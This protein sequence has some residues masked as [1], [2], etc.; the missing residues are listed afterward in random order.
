L[1]GLDVSS[2]EDS[3][4]ERGGKCLNCG[5]NIMDPIHK[6]HSFCNDCW[7]LLLKHPYSLEDGGC[8]YCDEPEDHPFHTSWSQADEDFA[9]DHGISYRD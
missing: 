3:K 9:V 7:I 4:R 5:I 6:D 8:A 2:L 1:K